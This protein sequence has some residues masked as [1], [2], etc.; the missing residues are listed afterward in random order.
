[1]PPLIIA[2]LPI[3]IELKKSKPVGGWQVPATHAAV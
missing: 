2:L 3:V 1:M